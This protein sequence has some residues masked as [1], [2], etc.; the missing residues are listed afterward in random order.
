MSKRSGGIKRLSSF[1]LFL[2]CFFGVVPFLFPS[3]V[4]LCNTIPYH[5]IPSIAVPFLTKIVRCSFSFGMDMVFF[6]SYLV[7]RALDFD[8][9]YFIINYS[10]TLLL[11]ENS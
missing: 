7:Q 9:N 5:T 2:F 8:I 3:T 10:T 11:C 4:V 6:Y 1:V